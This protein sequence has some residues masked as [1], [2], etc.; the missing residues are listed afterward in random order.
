LQPYKIVIEKN[1]YFQFITTAGTKY[2]CYFLSY[3]EYF[4][5]YKEVASNIYSVNVEIIESKRRAVALDE[6]TGLTIVEIVKR[7]LKGLEDVVVYVCDSSDGR[8]LLRKR[9]F[10]LWFRKYDDGTVIKIDGHISVPNFNIYNAILIHKD[11]PKK[12]RFIEVF[13]E[14]NATDDDK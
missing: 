13:N 1:N 12:N 2:A 14:L 6:R 4:K 3:A 7:F 10:D 8:E 9:K 5:S 11:N